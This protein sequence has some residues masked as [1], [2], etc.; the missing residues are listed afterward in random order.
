MLLD[1]EVYDYALSKSGIEGIALSVLHHLDIPI[2][3]NIGLSIMPGKSSQIVVTVELMNTSLQIRNRFTPEQ[4]QCYF[5]TEM[6]LKHL[7]RKRSFRYTYHKVVYFQGIC[8]GVVRPRT[9][10]HLCCSSHVHCY[11]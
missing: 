7:P 11:V 1:A 9:T 2:M 6:N 10:L 4:S 5:A 3:K 8:S